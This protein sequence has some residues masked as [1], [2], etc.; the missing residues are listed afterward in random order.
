MKIIRIKQFEDLLEEID[1]TKEP[2]ALLA[3]GTDIMPEVNE[4][5]FRKQTVYDLS[6]FENELHFVEVSKNEIEIGSLVSL[7]EIASNTTVIEKIPQLVEAILSIGSRQIR[8]MGTLA[9]NIANASPVADSAPVLLTTEAVVNVVSLNGSREIS[10]DD[11]FVDYK[12]TS[13]NGNEIIRSISVPFN[14]VSGKYGFR[15][16]ASQQEAISKITFAYAIDAKSVRFASGGA[17]KFPVRLLNVEHN[18]GQKQSVEEWEKV[19]S[20]D[21]SPISDLRST[22]EYRKKVLANIISELA[23]SSPE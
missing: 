20:K 13:L 18:W 19:L 5:L 4:G 7:A 8:N 1:R 10:I 2:F 16:V 6:P 11:F 21:I 15:K 23:L 22:V 3:G 17:T 14:S 12:K 9:G